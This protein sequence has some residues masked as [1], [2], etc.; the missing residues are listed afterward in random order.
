MKAGGITGAELAGIIIPAVVGAAGIGTG[1]A[2]LLQEPPEAAKPNLPGANPP[3][4]VAGVGQP[5]AQP[6]MGRQ[7]N[8]TNQ[9][10]SAAMAMLR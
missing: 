8:E 1:V 9:R 5:S 7:Q 3:A 6:F 10:Q 2:G 4:P